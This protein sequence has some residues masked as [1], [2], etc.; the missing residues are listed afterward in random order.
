M[1]FQ[2]FRGNIR[3][4]M[5]TCTAAVALM[6][7]PVIA[8]SPA[9]VYPVKTV[10]APVSNK[11][12]DFTWME[13]DKQV[14]L[15]EVGKNKVILLNFWAT[16]CAPCRKEIP[17]LVELSKELPNTEFIVLGVSV[18]R[19]Q[20]AINTVSKFARAKNLPYTVIVANDELVKAYGGINAIPSTFILTSE[21]TV[22]EKIAGMKSKAEFL[23]AIQKAMKHNQSQK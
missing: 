21:G 13:G 9:K 6:V 22:S 14:S 2:H 11:V 4:L 3:R 8:Q 19:D 1:I 7:V 10:V 20:D 12:A 17:D 15:S 18:D 23:A 5:L 16:W